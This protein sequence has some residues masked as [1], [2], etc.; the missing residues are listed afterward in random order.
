[1]GIHPLVSGMVMKGVASLASKALDRFDEAK[2]PQSNRL[3]QGQN[4]SA[5]AK[6][7]GQLLQSYQ[8]MLSDR[9]RPPYLEGA[10]ESNHQA[11]EE[12]SAA[13]SQHLETMGISLD[14]GQLMEQL[15]AGLPELK[16]NGESIG[17]AFQSGIWQL[18]GSG[19]RGLLQQAHREAG[20]GQQSM[21]SVHEL[22]LSMKRKFMV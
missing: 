10:V 16:V 20:S 13:F 14:E 19:E 9:I 2:A 4:M 7:F 11:L 21:E 8:E 18:L 15:E 17:S 1:M 22:A 12:V 5:E 6:E 3:E